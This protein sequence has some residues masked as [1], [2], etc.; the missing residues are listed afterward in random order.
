METCGE[1]EKVFGVMELCSGLDFSVV[2]SSFGWLGFCLH[3]YRVFVE[4][5]LFRAE[6]TKGRF[7]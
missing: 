4:F 5:L 3:I 1:D 7:T 2:S 6:R